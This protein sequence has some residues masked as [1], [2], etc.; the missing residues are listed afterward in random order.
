MVQVELFAPSL[1]TWIQYKNQHGERK[2]IPAH[3]SLF[4]LVSY[5]CVH[6]CTQTNKQMM[7]RN[8][9]SSSLLIFKELY[10]CFINIHVHLW[11]FSMFPH[12]CATY[13]KWSSEYSLENTGLLILQCCNSVILIYL[14]RERKGQRF[15]DQT[16]V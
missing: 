5:A 8:L 16:L 13:I 11:K 2:S 1:T 6:I 3:W 10:T 4:L 9:V 12:V 14:L 7:E 15:K